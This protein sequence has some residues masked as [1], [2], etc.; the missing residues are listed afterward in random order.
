MKQ[1]AESARAA[2]QAGQ[3]EKAADIVHYALMEGS[4]TYDQNMAAIAKAAKD[5]NPKNRRR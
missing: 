2:V 4:G 5:T 1:V 3:P